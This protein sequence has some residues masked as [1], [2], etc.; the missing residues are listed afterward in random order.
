VVDFDLTHC[1]TTKHMFLIR[2]LR[3]SQKSILSHRN[4]G[5]GDNLLAAA[6][7][8]NYAKIT[9]RSLVICWS[10]SRYLRDGGVNAFFQFFEP[11]REIQGVPVVVE[12]RIDRLSSWIISYWHFLVPYPDLVCIAERM[13]RGSG[14]LKHLIP[15]YVP[16]DGPRGFAADRR[17]EQEQKIV[18]AGIEKPQHLMIA[19]ACY[20]PQEKLKPFFDSLKLAPNLAQQVEAFSQAHFRDKLVIGVH[21]RHY[22]VSLPRA[23]H[24]QYWISPEEGLALC[25]DKIHQAIG[26]AGTAEHVVFLSTDSRLVQEPYPDSIPS[27][28]MVFLLRESV[29]AGNPDLIAAVRPRRALWVIAGS[30]RF[31]VLFNAS[32]LALPHRVIQTK[33]GQ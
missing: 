30:L 23:D 6:N 3:R 11:P 15:G 10:R 7:A 25:L 2:L 27:R 16:I 28:V 5:L 29:R 1:P 32:G 24:S 21:V 26:R 13:L 19:T 18:Y 8:W 20:C 9:Q 22:D 31:G 33:C 4:S 17:H 12:S 14:V